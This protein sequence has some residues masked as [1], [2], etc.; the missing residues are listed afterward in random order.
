MLYPRMADPAKTEKVKIF[1]SPTDVTLLRWVGLVLSA[2][3]VKYLATPLNK[4]TSKDVVFQWSQAC[5]TAFFK[6]K[7]LLVSAPVLAYPR[8][9]SEVRF[10]LETDAMQL[11]WLRCCAVSATGEW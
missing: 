4:L 2:F 8:F 10:I 6:L 9:G 3:L 1:P 7:E 5:V 11:C